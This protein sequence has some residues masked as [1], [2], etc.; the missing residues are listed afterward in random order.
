[1]AK[2]FDSSVL[3]T[4]KKSREKERMREERGKIKRIRHNHEC[5]PGPYTQ[6]NILPQNQPIAASSP[7]LAKPLPT[8]VVPHPLSLSRRCMISLQS[9]ALLTVFRPFFK[10]H[11]D[12]PFSGQDSTK[13]TNAAS[14]RIQG[15]SDRAVRL[16]T[17]PGA[18]SGHHVDCRRGY[19]SNSVH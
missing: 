1:M 17:E 15:V 13:G 8:W 12:K 4:F 18:L 14:T 7:Y 11:L 10:I 3:F 6:I 5:D 2:A 9:E 19:S 16:F